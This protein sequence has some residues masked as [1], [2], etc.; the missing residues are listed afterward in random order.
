M[1]KVSIIIPAY[2]SEEYVA[3]C[4]ESLIIQ[5]FC[6]FEIICVN[7]ASTDSTLQIL[8]KYS[9]TYSNVVVLSNETN[10]G[11]SYS[12]NRGMRE[13]KGEYVLF[14][15]SDD[16]LINENVISTLYNLASMNELDLLRFNLNTDEKVIEKEMYMEGRDLFEYLINEGIYKWESVR[17]FVRRSALLENNIWFDE[18]IVGCEDVL[19]STECIWKLK[20][21]AEVPEKYYFYF[22]HEGSITRSKI[23]IQKMEGWLRAIN[24]LYLVLGES[25]L[26][27]RRYSLVKFINYLSRCCENLL[28]HMESSLVISNWPP[29]ILSLYE[30]C[31]KEGRLIH[32]HVIFSNWDLILSYT[33]IYI[34]GAGAACEELLR[35]TRKRIH[36]SG[37]VVTDKTGYEQKIHE[38]VIRDVSDC[39]L[40]KESLMII[41]LTGK[42]RQQ[43][44]IEKL[45]TC[46]FKNYL[47]VAKE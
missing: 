9:A 24:S 13:A 10:K 37:I 46:G 35:K 40:V 6:D 47:V 21:T 23:T 17:N 45:V 20:R 25:I 12:R 43:D 3:K 8:M 11:L 19:F 29:E 1:L 30:N 16:W 22:R 33:S 44:V 7:D 34:Y 38:L 42:E 15:D 36:Y 26:D 27:K 39:S 4:L 2:N 28:Y 18:S 5:K 41:C 32:N 31:F 14:V